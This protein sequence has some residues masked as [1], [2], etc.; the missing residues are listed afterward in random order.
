MTTS[1]TKIALVTGASRGLGRNIAIA[2]ACEPQIGHGAV[3]DV[4][5][6]RSGEHEIH[7][8]GMI[9][10]ARVEAGTG[11]A[12]ENTPDSGLP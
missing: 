4:G 5:C 1:S 11:P 8:D 7:V 6:R 2:L 9:R 10:A 12:G 3:K